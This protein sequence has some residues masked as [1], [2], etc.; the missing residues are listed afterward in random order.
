MHP[1][2]KGLDVLLFRLFAGLQ[3][4]DLQHR[5]GTGRPA[6]VRLGVEDQ[7]QQAHQ[8]LLGKQGG[9]GLVFFRAGLGDAA[10]HL[11]AA[12]LRHRHQAQVAVQVAQENGH[13][14]APGKEFLH[15]AERLGLLTGG[16]GVREGEQEGTVHRAQ[17]GSDAL[18]RHLAADPQA[19]VQQAQGIAHAA[20]GG[21]GDQ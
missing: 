15:Q 1:L 2:Q 18:L 7:V 5:P 6:G 4:A 11:P 20:L 14:V 3:H 19:H 12:D 17:N 16:Q 13:V 10:Q 21:L 8:P 9:L